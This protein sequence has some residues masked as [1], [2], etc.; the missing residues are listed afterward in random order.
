MGTWHEVKLKLLVSVADGIAALSVDLRPEVFLFYLYFTF[1][2]DKSLGSRSR[3]FKRHEGFKRKRHQEG[4]VSF[5]FSSN[6][7]CA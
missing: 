7:F 3:N 2:L 4:S 5:I 6:L 1:Q